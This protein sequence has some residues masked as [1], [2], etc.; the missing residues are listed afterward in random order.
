MSRSRLHL[1]KRERCLSREHRGRDCLS[2]RYK[3]EGEASDQ[4]KGERY[5][6]K[7]CSPFSW[8]RRRILAF[9]HRSYLLLAISIYTCHSGWETLNATIQW[10]LVNC[11]SD[12]IILPVLIP[13]QIS[14]YMFTDWFGCQMLEPPIE[15]LNRHCATDLSRQLNWHELYQTHISGTK[16]TLQ[17]KC[18]SV[19]II[20]E[21]SS[22]VDKSSLIHMLFNMFECN[23]MT[24]KVNYTRMDG[25]GK[26]SG[27]QRMAH[28]IPRNMH[29]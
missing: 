23:I 13:M 26:C 3:E 15:M 16:F 4:G 28:F 21:W 14:V 9:T 22:Y 5:G 24:S 10:L 27:N 25:Y 12:R 6:S 8:L 18:F 11:I 17:W 20:Y 29:T 2:E 1:D 7:M 19:I